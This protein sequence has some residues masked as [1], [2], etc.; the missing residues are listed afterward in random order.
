MFHVKHNLSSPISIPV[1]TKNNDISNQYSTNN[2]CFGPLQNSPPSVWKTR[3]NKRLGD[4][5][6][7]NQ[8]LGSKK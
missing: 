2:S 7:K 3:L 4:S 5:P 1:I 6:I 8:Y